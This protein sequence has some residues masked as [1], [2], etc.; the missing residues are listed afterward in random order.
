MAVSY[1]IKTNWLSLCVELM[2]TGITYTWGDVK[3]MK[4]FELLSSHAVAV[5]EYAYSEGCSNRSH[6]DDFSFY[7]I[8]LDMVFGMAENMP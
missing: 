3:S 8:S 7:A 4:N 6:D 2:R 1:N 5:V